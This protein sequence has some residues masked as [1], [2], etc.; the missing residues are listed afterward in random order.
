M[1]PRLVGEGHLCCNLYDLGS[2]D[3]LRLMRWKI[4]STLQRNKEHDNISRAYQSYHIQS[5]K[6]SIFFS[7]D[8]HPGRTNH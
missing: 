1:V 5:Y 6:E 4:E 2:I 3:F 8:Q 7:I